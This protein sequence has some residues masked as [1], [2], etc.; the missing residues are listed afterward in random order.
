LPI[1]DTA[2]T[3]ECLRRGTIGLFLKLDLITQQFAETLLCWKHSGFSVDYANWNRST[4]RRT[5][6]A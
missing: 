3:A 5:V 2:H 6:G 1:H 4:P